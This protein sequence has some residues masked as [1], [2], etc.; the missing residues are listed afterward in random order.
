MRRLGLSPNAL[1][2]S[3]EK[4]RLWADIDGTTQIRPVPY[5][6]QRCSI[7]IGA[8]D[9]I[10]RAEIHIG[11]ADWEDDGLNLSGLQRDWQLPT[12]QALRNPHEI[13]GKRRRIEIR[14]ARD[15][16][17]K[18]WCLFQGYMEKVDLGWSGS[19]NPR[20]LVVRAVSTIIDLD[21]ERHHFHVGQWRRTRGSVID[22]R[23]N[24]DPAREEARVCMRVMSEP[25][26]FNPGGRPNCDHR[27][28]QFTDGDREDFVH[29]FADAPDRQE[30]QDTAEGPVGEAEFWTVAR[31]LKYIQWAAVQPPIEIN[32]GWPKDF[33][34]H[35]VHSAQSYRGRPWSTTPNVVWEAFTPGSTKDP[36][37]NLDTLI[38]PYI[39]LAPDAA[40]NDAQAAALLK[41]LPDMS[42]HGMSTLE[43]LALVCHRAGMLFQVENVQNSAGETQVFLRFSIRGDRAIE[44]DEG[45]DSPS[46]GDPVAGSGNRPR[47]R[48]SRGVYLWV[49]EDRTDSSTDA[50]DAERFKYD[51]HFEGQVSITDEHTRGRVTVIGAPMRDEIYTGVSTSSR[52]MLPGWFP[53]E[54]GW[55]TQLSTPET[56][57]ARVGER[58]QKNDWSKI[59]GPHREATD[60]V[61]AGAELAG[62]YWVLNED[63]AFDADSYRRL[64]GP[65]DAEADWEPLKFVDDLQ[66]NL[67]PGVGNRTQDNSFTVR[68]RPFLPSLHRAGERPIGVYVALSFDGGTSWW[69]PANMSYKVSQ[70]RAAIFV[71]TADLRTIEALDSD[72]NPTGGNYV[73]AYINGQLRVAVFASMQSDQANYVS[74]PSK[75]SGNH[76]EEVIVRPNAYPYHRVA[77]FNL[78]ICLGNPTY[79]MFP[80]DNSVNNYDALRA[81][82]LNARD[83]V[84]YARVSGQAVIP[85]LYRS[86]F[87]A[88]E[89][90]RVGDEVLGIQTRRKRTFIDFMEGREADVPGP[91][92]IGIQYVYSADGQS[93]HLLLEDYD[94]DVDSVV[95]NPMLGGQR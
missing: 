72:G 3:A 79:D 11:L 29:L 21:R 95:G 56:L 40:S 53:D 28:L 86:G 81:D 90:Y 60:T 93:T 15:N 80:A 89:G 87:G 67:I 46:Y 54:F 16:P 78:P 52:M 55:D 66:Y 23:D 63:G 47:I 51:V 94:L 30:R 39:Q 2:Y 44:T 71:T 58:G 4:L 82:V 49:S 74:R 88:Q 64:D 85:Y 92:I 68:R 61:Q 75:V 20:W 57:I 9:R 24:D 69:R 17:A 37:P 76:W 8:N 5:E 25:V 1:G 83:E 59:Y 22:L 62:R 48:S 36:Q 32:E 18:D 35:V 91:H 42:I 12:T 43:A 6:I 26:V 65:W 45:L 50:S 13:L 14:T 31:I 77:R 7:S 27:P 10:P 19:S 41:V 73:T 38:D 33:S 84:A 34:E 70:D